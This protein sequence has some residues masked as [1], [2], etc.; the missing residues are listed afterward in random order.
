MLLKVGLYIYITIAI[1]VTKKKKNSK[2]CQILWCSLPIFTHCHTLILS[3]IVFSQFCAEWLVCTFFLPLFLFFLPIF[4]YAF[5]CLLIPSHPFFFFVLLSA[6]NSVCTFF[7][8]LIHLLMCRIRYSGFSFA[9][10]FVAKIHSWF[11]SF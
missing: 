6:H 10:Q 9:K 5:S 2:K 7:N 1:F 3:P 8:L 4:Y 11:P